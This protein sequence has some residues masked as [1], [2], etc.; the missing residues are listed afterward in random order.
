MNAADTLA[1]RP[2]ADQQLST[3]AHPEP[4]HALSA[5]WTFACRA[6]L[7][8]K[9][10]PEELGDVIGIPIIFTLMFT[11]LFGGAL[12]GSTQATCNSCSQARSF[13]SSSS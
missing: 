10:V 1:V 11:C 2:G 4:A 7:K 9:H 5:S 3:A 12:A 8:L 6:M 13:S